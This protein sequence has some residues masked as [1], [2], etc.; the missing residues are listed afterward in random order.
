MKQSCEYNRL[1]EELGA[2]GVCG[3]GVVL[4]HSSMKALGTSLTPD[5][6]IDCL[7]AAVG[8]EGTLLFPALTYENVN[9]AHPVFHSPTTQPC[10]GLLPRVFWQ[11]PGVER[12]ENPTHSVCAWGRL[13]H[14]LTVGHAMDN[15][16]VG[17]HSPFMLLPVVGGKL[18]FI[19]EVLHACTFMHGIEEMVKPPF[20]RPTPVTYTVNGQE[21]QY[22]GGDQFG[23]GSEFQRIGDILEEPDIR[24]GKLLEAEC[25]LIDT[26]ALL[27]AALAE[28]RSNPYAFVTDI[29]K[30]I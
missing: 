10:I 19:G 26:R 13:A 29:S 24:R 21:R 25:S 14:R 17:P 20:I 28:M 8:E 7:Q 1:L 12:S 2:L 22:W 16:P 18:L 30:W 6:V 3:G 9:Q 23:W 15:T 5:E 11:R 4:V 27:A